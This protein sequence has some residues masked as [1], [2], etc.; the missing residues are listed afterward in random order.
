VLPPF[1]VSLSLSL[2]FCL[3]RVWRIHPRS[4]FG[5]VNATDV[6]PRNGV[7]VT[8]TEESNFALVA[9]AA[10]PPLD[11]PAK[12][13]LRPRIPPRVFIYSTAMPNASHAELHL[14]QL[15]PSDPAAE[16]YFFFPSSPLAALQRLQTG[17]N[18]IENS[19]ACSCP[20]FLSSPSSPA[21]ASALHLRRFFV[22]EFA[23]RSSPAALVRETAE[24]NCNRRSSASPR[25]N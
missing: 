6:N 14:R 20:P 24:A 15:S 12:V 2:P 13:E 25:L 4:A 21:Y 18:G 8:R 17:T 10:N 11:I 22:G 1:L 3:S 16:S 9:R 7:K 23:G 19:S 5:N